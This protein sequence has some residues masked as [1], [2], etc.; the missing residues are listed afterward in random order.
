[1]SEPV[2]HGLFPT[3]VV[4]TETGREFTE[5]ELEFFKKSGE[6]TY[7]NEGNVTSLNRYIVNEPEM[8]TIK[9]EIEAAVNHYM[10]KI[11]VAKP[12]VKAYIT[13]SWL[14][15]TSE[16]Q[17]HHKHAHPNSFLSGVYYIDANE[18]NDKITFFEESYKQIKLTPSEWN[19]WN[20][21][22]WWFTV[23]TGQIVVFPSHLTHMVEQKAGNNVRCSL[24]F[25]TFLKGTI[26]ENETLTEL[27]NP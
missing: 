2:I 15:F 7:K 19:W 16:K 18:E 9:A 4:F 22:S 3:P 27:L 24:A 14:N 25:N 20:S 21:P 10:D 17:W 23:K 1:M 5:Q 11:I 6:T 8:A 12:E 13:Q 26:G